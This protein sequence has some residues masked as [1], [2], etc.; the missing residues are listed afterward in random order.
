MAI[1]GCYGEA[2]RKPLQQQR[3]HRQQGGKRK[4]PADE[5]EE[6]IDAVPRARTRDNVARLNGGAISID[7]CCSHIDIQRV[8]RGGYPRL[9]DGRIGAHCVW[10]RFEQL[11]AIQETMLRQK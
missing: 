1:G 6:R 9:F 8:Q 10:N 11:G 2:E 5:R 3:H 4:R 7:G